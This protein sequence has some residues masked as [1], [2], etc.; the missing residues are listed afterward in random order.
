[1][2]APRSSLLFIACVVLAEG[3]DVTLSPNFLGDDIEKF[4]Q[5]SAGPKSEFE[6]TVEYE[7]RRNYTTVD[8]T[9]SSEV[10]SGG[11]EA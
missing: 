11:S 2:Y 9:A 5:F 7:A 4:F 1:M 10:L 8:A 3:A 6:T